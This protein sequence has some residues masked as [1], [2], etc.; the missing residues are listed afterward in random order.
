MLNVA[1]NNLSVISRPCLDVAGSSMI[2]FRILPHWNI[3]PQILWHDMPPS[4]LKQ[5]RHF[6]SESND[7][8]KKNMFFHIYEGHIMQLTG[9]RHENKVLGIGCLG[10]YWVFYKSTQP[11][12]CQHV[13]SLRILL[14]YRIMIQQRCLQNVFIFSRWRSMP[15]TTEDVHLQISLGLCKQSRTFMK[16]NE[17]KPFVKP[18]ANTNNFI[19]IKSM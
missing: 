5:F 6:G 9:P 14:Y 11:V 16:R 7:S 19:N 12:P 4:Q 15:E 13:S 17:W 18:E 2:T 10:G 1:F 3:T 8:C